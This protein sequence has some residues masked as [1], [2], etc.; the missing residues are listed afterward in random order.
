MVG[1][2]AM[3]LG[4]LALFMI[5]SV[6]CALAPGIG[7]LTAARVVQGFG[8]GGLMTL[9]QALVGETI[10]PRQRGRYQGYLAAV[11]VA[12][13][14]FGPV[15]GGYLTQAFSLYPE[16]TVKENIR[17]VGD[18]RSVPPRD[19]ASRATR[20]LEMFDMLRFQESAQS[21]DAQLEDAGYFRFRAGGEY[22]AFNPTVFRSLHKFARGKKEEFDAYSSAVNTRAPMTLRDLIDRRDSGDPL[23]T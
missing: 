10:P 16:L 3:V 2:R 9:S 15:A 20:Y 5:G 17:Y 18:L 6:L 8:G 14:T 1:R 22:H 21:V 13:S 12:S 11:A 23:L 4:A 19:I 7:F